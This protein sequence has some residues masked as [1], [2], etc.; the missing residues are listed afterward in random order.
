MDY[1]V[2]F[3]CFILIIYN[4]LYLGRLFLEDGSID[5]EIDRRLNAGRKVVG[6]MMGLA[7]SE[8]LSTKAKL[9]VYNSV[10]LPT[11]MYGS[12]SWVC[13]TQHKSKLNAVGIMSFLRSI[14]VV[15]QGWT[16]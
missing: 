6:S 14:C 5:G 4:S 8:V 16:K 2:C 11:L 10:S 15:K 13:Q 1:F 9:A 7:R 12:E 3:C